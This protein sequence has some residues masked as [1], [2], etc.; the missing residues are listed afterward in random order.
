[1]QG[2]SKARATIPACMLR[3]KLCTRQVHTHVHVHAQDNCSS[4]AGEKKRARACTLQDGHGHGTTR[5][6]GFYIGNMCKTFLGPQSLASTLSYPI[7]LSLTNKAIPP[8]SHTWEDRCPVDDMQIRTLSTDTCCATSPDKPHKPA[9]T[10][11]TA[12]YKGSSQ[13]PAHV[14]NMRVSPI[15]PTLTSCAR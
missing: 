12:T 13:A 8:T 11:Y 1:M 5:P 14:N 6:G 2:N 7:K 15:K 4:D 9:P 10:S 3:A